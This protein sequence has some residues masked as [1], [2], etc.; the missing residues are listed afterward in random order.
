[1]VSSTIYA[2]AVASE[3]LKVYSPALFVWRVGC[4]IMLGAG[5][6]LAHSSDV[7][8]DING[9]IFYVITIPRI[10]LI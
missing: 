3:I 5:R 9:Q 10:I 2:K 1:L 6:P 4:E 8:S 7:L